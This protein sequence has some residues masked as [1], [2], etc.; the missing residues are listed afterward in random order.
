MNPQ[1]LED[2]EHPPIL[3]VFP[4]T[5]VLLLPGTL[6]PLHI[7]EERYRN[8]VRDALAG[9]RCL[10][11]AQPLE[12]R[13]D[14]RS[15]PEAPPGPANDLPESDRPDL[16]AIGCAGVIEPVQELADG[17]YVIF[18]RGVSRF[19]I[20]SELP[21]KDGYRRVEADY[22]EF[23]TDPT[24]TSEELDTARLLEALQAFGKRRQLE[25]DLSRL[26]EMPGVAVLNSLAMA[27]PFAAVEK[28]ALL[29]ATDA[30]TR[31]DMLITLLSMGIDPRGEG[32]EEAGLAPN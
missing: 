22:S 5:G 6:L 27:L 30:P 29:E 11:M 12:P 18:V 13:G 26:A 23:D 21:L 32:G 17:R 7:F 2:F 16:Y 15:D 24:S 10:G 25:F 4:L 3:P 9:D 1:A 8:M 28:Q 31:Q 14:H 19:R 20:V